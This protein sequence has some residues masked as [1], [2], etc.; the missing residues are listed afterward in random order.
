MS[1][2]TIN[3]KCSNSDKSSIVA[4]TSL[5][6]KEVKDKIADKT[7]V[8]A[9]LQ[10]LIYKGRVLKDDSTVEDY[11]ISDGDVIH[12]VKGAAAAA[13][14][15]PSAAPTSIPAPVSA[16]TAS[17]NLPP[18]PSG[19]NPLAAMMGGMGGIGGMGG[20]GGMQQMQDEMMRNPAMMQQMMNSPLMQK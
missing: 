5:T 20:T 4:A 19:Q 3:I 9:E 12:M 15:P 1:E 14:S 8:S 6:I 10:R 16:P 11:K 2:I 13:A 18:V 7:S 17:T